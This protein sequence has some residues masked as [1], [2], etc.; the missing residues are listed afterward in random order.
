MEDKEILLRYS[1][2]IDNN[3]KAL[4]RLS[5]TLQAVITNN[6]YIVNNIGGLNKFSSDVYNK[7][8]NA[9]LIIDALSICLFEKNV[10]EEK[11]FQE[12]IEQLA[13]QHEERVKEEMKEENKC[14]GECGHEAKGKTDSV[15][16]EK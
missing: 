11:R 2:C 1:D 9:L 5:D 16:A 7:L 14:N 4:N 13:K 8:N 15:G 12:V 6:N 3:A 10:I